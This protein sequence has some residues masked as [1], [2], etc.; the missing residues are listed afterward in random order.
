MTKPKLPRPAQ[1]W[2][3]A[4][5]GL[6]L[7]D[8]PGQV[9]SHD[10]VSTVR[11]LART[12]KV[13]HAGTLDPMATGL[14]TLGVGRA[15]KLLTYLVGA[16]KQY[17]ATIR[18]GV[19]TNTD[20]ADG[21]VSAR[22]GY[23]LPREP[24]LEQALAQLR[25]NIQQVPSTVSA[26]KVNGVRAYAR[27][28]AGEQVELAARNVKVSR[29]EVLSKQAQTLSDGTPVLDLE[30]VVD[31]SSG[32]YIRALARDLG[33]KLGSAGHLTRLR[34]TRVGE[35]QVSQAPTLEEL[36]QLTQSQGQLPVVPLAQAAQRMFPSRV[37]NEQETTAVR[38]GRFITP[39]LVAAVVAG[40]DE[41]GNLIALLQ[42]D[43]AQGR[44]VLVF[45]PA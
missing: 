20:D 42:D 1:T 34:R 10:V 16:S 22:P 39:S 32:T 43:Q 13:G 6:L 38:H 33:L 5:D 11:Y 41:Q 37:L 25:G 12:K 21:E 35:Y 44:P 9:T 8:K 40:F 19:A 23:T 17:T 30:V 27:A 2:Q 18:L 3:P 26:I 15:T 28:R 31:C 45:D 4:G 14:L 29:F 36:M 24:A 7:V